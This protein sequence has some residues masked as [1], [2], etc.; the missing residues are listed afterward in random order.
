MFE[1]QDSFLHNI[2]IFAKNRNKTIL[3]TYVP[4]NSLLLVHPVGRG[5]IKWLAQG[6][7]VI[8]S[9]YSNMYMDFRQQVQLANFLTSKEKQ[10]LHDKLNKVEPCWG[11]Q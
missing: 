1:D 9:T 8:Q 4:H 6:D 3:F 10:L 11:D 2:K 7:L 5:T